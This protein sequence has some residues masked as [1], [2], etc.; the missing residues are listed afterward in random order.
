M[1]LLAAYNFD[2]STGP[3]L[4][5]SGNGRD[6]T[7]ASPAT[8][9]VSGHTN[10]GLTQTSAGIFTAPAGYL[11]ALQTPQR[12]VMAWV[13]EAAGITGWVLEFNDSS[14]DSGCWGILFLSGQWQIQARNA[15]GFVRAAVS[16]PTDGLFHHVA[17][18]YDGT[19]V[20]LYLNGSL[21]ATQPL[22]GPLR[23][24]DVFRFQD[25]SGSNVTIDDVRFYGEAL[26]QTTI[27]SLA[28]I[29]V[30]VGRSGKPKIWSG[31]AWAQHQGKYWNGSAWVAV[32][33]KGYT[34]SGFVSSK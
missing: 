4:D 33:L 24:A 15:S 25:Q 1:S 29:P 3:V 21:A 10:G 17:G 16:R 19:N 27:A 6:I 7:L 31:S 12:T 11:T 20:R 26:D 8:R 32:P 28:S 30:T 5:A 34:G 14:I 2:E 13:K 23:T 22:A 18:T 9:T